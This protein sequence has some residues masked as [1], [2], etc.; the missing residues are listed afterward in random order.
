MNNKNGKMQDINQPA[1]KKALQFINESLNAKIW[2]TNDRLPSLSELAG[3]ARVSRDSMW[4]AVQRAKQI[5]LVTVTPGGYI[6][7]GVPST[8]K[9]ND[10]NESESG[11]GAT[12]RNTKRQLSKDIAGGA[13]GHHG[14]LPAAKELLS[15]YHVCFRT[16]QKVLQSLDSNG[17]IQ[18]AGK[19]YSLPQTTANTHRNRIVFITC[20]G[21]FAQ[22]SALNHEHNRIV[23][24]FE[25]ECVRIGLN[26]ELI[27]IDFYDSAE[28]RRAVMSLTSGDSIIGYVFDVWWYASETFQRS[29][30]DVLIKLATFRKPVAILDEIGSFKL[31]VQ[32]SSNHL[33]QVYSLEGKRAGERMAGHLINLGH[34]SAAFISIYEAQWS[35]DRYEGAL[36]HF[37][38]K[39]CNP[40]VYP[41]VDTEAKDRPVGS[42]ALH[43]A[44][45]LS[46]TEIRKLITVGRTPSQAK[47]L[48]NQWDIFI[49]TNSF[50]KAGDH[51]ADPGL[52]KNLNGLGGI[53]HHGFDADYL[54]TA[55]QAIINTAAKHVFGQGLKPLF[56]KALTLK[57]VTAWICVNDI[58]AFE[59]IL[60]LNENK[61]RVPQDMSVAGF[62]NLPVRSLEERLTSL[63][64]NTMGFINRMLGFILRP[65][66]PQGPYR[67]MAIEVEGIIM[68]RATTGKAA[69]T[70]RNS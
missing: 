69:L 27:E 61:I 64:F 41:V 18:R 8:A 32:Y 39:G 40:G 3:L 36:S 31:P 11:R 9:R 33:L 62:D 50:K 43:A 1:V 15:R 63:D 49:K 6:V 70:D 53:L 68:E 19:R 60:F 14:K 46:D 66:K 42:L 2:K 24:L 57:D 51:F 28:S 12:W 17:T 44:S 52:K 23:N 7:A 25:S 4:K 38:Q 29:N 13:F 59:A 37:N 16:M 56:E 58:T 5:S 55:S 21:H 47:D 20:L 54:E 26:I 67:H 34:R 65:P 30:L 35:R 10:E 22:T 48:E 45:G